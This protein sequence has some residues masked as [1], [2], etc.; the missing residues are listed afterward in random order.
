LIADLHQG[1]KT[2]DS[3]MPNGVICKETVHQKKITAA[4]TVMANRHPET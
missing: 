1:G 2:V 3:S 4:L